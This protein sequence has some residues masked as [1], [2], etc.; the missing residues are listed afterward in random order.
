MANIF[1]DTN[2]LLPDPLFKS[3]FNSLLIKLVKEGKIKIYIPSIVFE[4][5][6][7][8]YEQFLLEEVSNLHKYHQ[9]IQ[10]VI[11][12][13]IKLPEISV[14]ECL[15][16][17]KTF[18]NLNFEN[19]FFHNLEYKNHIL[20]ELVK[21]S[22]NRIKPFSNNK[23][24]F[25]DCII[26]LTIVEEI[27]TN[28]L[29]ENFFLTNNVHDFYDES[30]ENIHKDLQND[31]KEI[32]PHKSVKEFVIKQKELLRLK[33]I[34]EF[35][36]W[37]E[38]QHI[39]NFYLQTAIKGSLWDSVQGKLYDNLRKYDIGKIYNNN[40][41]GFLSP[42]VEK[43]RIKI[44]GTKVIIVDKFAL[45]TCNIAFEFYA[46]IYLPDIQRPVFTP[47]ANDSFS[48]SCELNFTLYKEGVLTFNEVENLIIEEKNNEA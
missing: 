44:K 43:Q 41:I 23:Q 1:L 11:N 31:C 46:S 39:N 7:N 19:G 14:A 42:A 40:L 13:D 29:K 24:E 30:K 16:D 38:E 3:D 2:I 47:Q 10:K 8:K 45:V 5:L 28:N 12:Q 21:R 9:N 27:K 20:P 48:A 22:I 4:E 17:F 25:R 35:E 15:T 33:E 18:Y 6:T 36:K 37:V 32:K 34:Y 26:W